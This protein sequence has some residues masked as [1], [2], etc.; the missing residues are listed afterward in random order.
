MYD[1]ASV[2]DQPWPE[3]LGLDA[4]VA[5][6]E[7]AMAV[8]GALRK[9]KSDN[10]LSMNAPVDLV[11]VY[12]DIHG[13]EEDVSGVMHIEKLEL[14]D[15]EP[16]IESVVTGVDLDY[17]LVGPEYGAQVPDIEAALEGDD[18]EVEDGVMHVAGVELDPEMFTIE[19]SREYVG[20]GD[21]L[22]AGDAIVI[23]QH[24]D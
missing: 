1:E 18:Y 20:D 24:A 23:V 16:E 12:G 4:D 7:T 10:Q 13:F 6:G 19:E 5:A 11:E 17:S 8:V 21:M 2:H 14:L 9:Y 22:E 3:P 15:E